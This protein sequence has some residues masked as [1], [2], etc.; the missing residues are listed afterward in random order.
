MPVFSKYSIVECPS[1]GQRSKNPSE[2]E[3]DKQIKCPFCHVKSI[4]TEWRECH[5][6]PLPLEVEREKTIEA[7][8]DN[9]HFIRQ[10]ASSI[11]MPIEEVIK[12]I[13]E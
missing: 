12:M 10:L 11:D 3:S 7:I 8:K 9:I 4:A 6:E 1:C 13:K 5:S 2:I